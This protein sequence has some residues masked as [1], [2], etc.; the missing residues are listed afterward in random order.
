MAQSNTPVVLAILAAGAIIGAAIL[1]SRPGSV[2]PS[3]SD[4]YSDVK[5]G[6]AA[7]LSDPGSATFQAISE[8][9]K[10]FAYCGEVNAKNRMGGYVGFRKFYAVRQST[11]GWIVEIDGPLAKQ[12]CK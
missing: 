12:M 10:D 5:A 8:Q 6:V 11:G 3:K 7:N 2:D 9:V 4:P 1:F